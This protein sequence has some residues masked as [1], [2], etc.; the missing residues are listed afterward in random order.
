MAVYDLRK[1]TFLL[2]VDIG[3]L[4]SALPQTLINR[5][6]SGQLIRCSASVGANYR[7]ARRAKSKA[8][9]I[10]KLKI[11]EEETD[12]TLYFLDLLSEFNPDR[13]QQIGLLTSETAEIL[14]IIVAAIITSR[15]KPP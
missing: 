9:F 4:V 14:K 11:V 12:E 3:R 1:R 5:S 13:R 15:S 7:A 10:N 2:A 6:Y 8:D